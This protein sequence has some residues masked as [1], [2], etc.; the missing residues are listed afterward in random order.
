[1]RT[2]E[3]ALWKRGAGEVKGARARRDVE[4]ANPHEGVDDLLC[5]ALAEITLISIRAQIGEGKYG[6]R[7]GRC[8]LVNR[9]FA[10]HPDET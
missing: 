5:D 8:P 4:A 10:I 9:D 6:D 1:M 7:G 3:T 2:G